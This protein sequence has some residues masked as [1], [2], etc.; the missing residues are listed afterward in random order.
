MALRGIL[1]TR[2]IQYH[3]YSYRALCVILLSYYLTIMSDC[4]LPFF[5]SDNIVG[6]SGNIVLH[7]PQG[8]PKLYNYHLSLWTNTSFSGHH[9]DKPNIKNNKCYSSN[10]LGQFAKCLV[11]FVKAQ[12]SYYLVI[13]TERYYQIMD[14]ITC[15]MSFS[16]DCDHI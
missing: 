4:R 8:H 5:D 12:N 3:H 10:Q 13:S 16:L 15:W 7:P 11:S 1:L 14:F 2:A 6:I 9:L